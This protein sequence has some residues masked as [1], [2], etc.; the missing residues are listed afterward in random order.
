[1]LFLSNNWNLSNKK[2][3][4]DIPN[5]EQE[6]NIIKTKYIKDPK[7]ESYIMNPNNI[8]HC[9]KKESII[10]LI[11]NTADIIIK[12]SDIEIFIQNYILPELSSPCG[13]LREQSCHLISKFGSI[14][15]KNNN[16]LENI[17]RKLCELMQND[18]QL[19]VKLYASIAIGSLFEKEITKKLLKGNIKNIFEINLK[20]ME[21]IDAEEIMENLQ[22][23][24][25]NFTEES[26]QYIVQL[27]EY[28]I[29][30][31]N[32]IISKEEDE[33]AKF[34][35]NY[36][37]QSNIISTFCNF[38]QYFINDENIY[39]KIE[40]YIDVLLQHCLNNI[41]DK[42]EEGL[43]IIEF[44]LKYGNTIPNHIWKFFIPL[45]ES[46]IGSK[47]EL[48]EFKKEFPK[49]IFIGHGYESI[50]DIA[51]LVCIFIAKDPNA[52]INMQ[53][54]NGNKYFDYVIKLIES[55]IS[56]SESKSSYTEI[57]YSLRLINTVFDCY[58]GKVDQ[59]LDHII[60]YILLKYKIN[61]IDK[62]LENYLQNLLSACFIY[63]SLKTLE[64]FQ[65]NKCTQDIFIFWFKDLDKLE[66][67]GDMKYNLIGICSLISIDQNKQDKL[68]IDNMK[69]ILEKIYIITEKINKKIKENEKDYNNEEDLNEDFGENEENEGGGIN[70][71]DEKIKNIIDGEG[72][73]YDEDLSYEEEDD[74]DKPLT[75]F[76]KQ[77]PILFVKNT[78][79]AVSQKSPDIYKIIMETLGDKINILNSIFNDEEQR[80]ANKNK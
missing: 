23:I 71:I 42:L 11:K 65:K 30:Y 25:K 27:S 49:Q 62:K 10:F 8:P 55:I 29:Q 17:I 19:S 48:D 79:N 72:F 20:L 24:V 3:I 14:I 69:Q 52:F 13:L 64:I 6:K 36:S 39:P 77:S 75:N 58:K 73:D 47:E 43:D 21:E 7:D 5:L 57:K 46:V 67:M 63:D 18:P 61:K 78:L 56:I 60:K 41:Y 31:F 9:L 4:N 74:D 50:L 80:L 35:D 45:I 26:Q 37:L 28:L 38:I 51:K 70:N 22:E 32:K 76:E 12:N 15:Y 44:V 68:I 33:D 54:K 2:I 1:M 34:I 16:L 40:K 66:R 53:D 59:F